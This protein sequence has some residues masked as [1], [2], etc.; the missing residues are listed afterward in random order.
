MKQDQDLRRRILPL[1]ELVSLVQQ[2][3]AAG[4]TVVFTN[5]CFDILHAGHI[6]SLTEAATHGSRLVVAINA[7]A[8]VKKL[9]GNN[10]PVNNE[11]SRA[12]V[13][14]SIRLVDAVVIFEE[15]TPLKV[16]S[17]ILPDVMVKGGDYKVEDIAG[18]KEVIEAGGRVIINPIL[19][20][21]STTNIIEKL[22]KD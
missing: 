19:N 3:K 20:G 4:E 14:S 6:A 15:E 16:V 12:L 9:K 7:D 10:R 1:S 11:D 5:G 8:S 18:A 2:W 22:R 21:F 17:A 13:M